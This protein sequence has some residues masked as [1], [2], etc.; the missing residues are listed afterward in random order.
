MGVFLY[1]VAFPSA[2]KK[3]DVENYRQKAQVCHC[4]E[5]VCTGF[6]GGATKSQGII[7]DLLAYEDI[8]DIEEE[9]EPDTCKY[10]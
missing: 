5:S 7:D 4:G 3:A 1:N 2:E 6:I 10:F 9:E 8:E